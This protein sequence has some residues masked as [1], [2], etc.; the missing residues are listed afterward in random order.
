MRTEHALKQADLFIG[1]EDQISGWSVPEECLWL[2]MIPSRSTGGR[3]ATP[4]TPGGKRKERKPV[5]GSRF[6]EMVDIDLDE[7]E[8]LVIEGQE[9]VRR[10]SCLFDAREE[11]EKLAARAPRT[12]SQRAS[13]FLGK[14]Y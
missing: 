6:V 3:P 5:N 7:E 2:E 10:G 4:R 9:T 11:Q 1:D 12:P 14:L 13:S 8:L